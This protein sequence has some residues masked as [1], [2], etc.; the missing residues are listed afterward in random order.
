MANEK[1]ERQCTCSHDNVV[2][3]CNYYW[4]GNEM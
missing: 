2:P 3:L 1:Q 4:R